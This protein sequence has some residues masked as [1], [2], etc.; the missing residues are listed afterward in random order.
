MSEKLFYDFCQREIDKREIPSQR[1]EVKIS[2]RDGA[3][4]K[5]RKDACLECA[6]Q[7]ETMLVGLPLGIQP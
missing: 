4:V 7:I 1:F 6:E 3:S 5:F 2:G